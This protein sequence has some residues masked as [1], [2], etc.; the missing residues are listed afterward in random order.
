MPQPAQR[1]A[2]RLGQLAAERGDRLA[3]RGP[4]T[5]TTAIAAGGRPEERA[6]MVEGAIIQIRK[7]EIQIARPVLD[8]LSAPRCILYAP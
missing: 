1:R 8:R 2:P 5:R 7:T 4:E 3:R 6:K